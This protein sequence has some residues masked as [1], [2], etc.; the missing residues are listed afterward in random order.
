MSATKINNKHLKIAV[1]TDNFKEMATEYDVFVD[2][3]LFI[4]EIIDSSEKAILITH[5]RRWGKH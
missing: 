4:K 3:T 2:K 1:G 5:P